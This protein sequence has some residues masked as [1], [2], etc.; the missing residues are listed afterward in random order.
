MAE[1]VA[2]AASSVVAKIVDPELIVSQKDS[3]SS[4]T[5]SERAC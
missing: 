2:P 3:L 5:T 4:V 1:M